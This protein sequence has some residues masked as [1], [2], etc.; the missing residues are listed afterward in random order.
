MMSNI[1]F[2]DSSASLLLIDKLSDTSTNL[3]LEYSF[4][5][6]NV[7]IMSNVLLAK[8]SL[9]YFNDIANN[10]FSINVRNVTIQNNKLALGAIFS[11]YL[12]CKMVID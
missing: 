3:D 4:D 9:V 7:D 8:D 10:K 5:I 1:E 6:E 12:N 11:L 2:L